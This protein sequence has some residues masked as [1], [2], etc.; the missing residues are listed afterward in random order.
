MTREMTFAE[1]GAFLVAAIDVGYKT[2]ALREAGYL[3]WEK[4][5]IL[6]HDVDESLNGISEFLRI[7]KE[8]KVISTFHFRTRSEGYNFYAPST[9]DMVRLIGRTHEVGLHF[10]GIQDFQLLHDLYGFSNCGVEVESTSKHFPT[11]G[12][13]WPHTDFSMPQIGRPIRY[14]YHPAYNGAGV[15]CLM[16]GREG[17][18]RGWPEDS[19]NEWPRM[20]VVTHPAYWVEKAPR[21][22]QKR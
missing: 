12:A 8:L 11:D 22:R 7:E 19:F 10:D 17:W 13:E 21:R 20:Q 2:L 16:D 6:R 18:L 5:L 15:K 14:A 3:D 1:Y 4:C 9:Q